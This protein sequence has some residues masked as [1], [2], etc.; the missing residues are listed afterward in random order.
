MRV[1][2]FHLR[3]SAPRDVRDAASRGAGVAFTHYDGVAILEVP[4]L[5]AAFEASNH[6]HSDWTKAQG[7]RMLT[8]CGARSTSVGDML[9]APDGLFVVAPVGFVKVEETVAL[10]NDEAA[11]NEEHEVPMT[12]AKHGFMVRSGVNP[13]LILTTTGEF[14]A[15]DF[16]GPGHQA[17][18]KVFKTWGGAERRAAS[19]GCG[20]TVEAMR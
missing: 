9:E 15:E 4:S 18:A 1:K 3:S 17:S 14:L 5:D 20:D 13:N 6:V 7:V 8:E 12:K 11:A 2:V 10:S 19:R 16:C